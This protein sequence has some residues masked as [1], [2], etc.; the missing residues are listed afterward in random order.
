MNDISIRG[1]QRLS[2]A[3][4]VEIDGGPPAAE[5]WLAEADALTAEAADGVAPTE[6]APAGGVDLWGVDLLARIVR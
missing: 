5:R 4:G 2:T 3:G 6:E 1:M